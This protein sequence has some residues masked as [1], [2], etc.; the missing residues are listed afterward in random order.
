ML[1]QAKELIYEINYLEEEV[2]DLEK[3]VLSLY[4][5]FF[6][7]SSYL[8]PSTLVQEKA[9]KCGA[10]HEAQQ[11]HEIQQ[12]SRK[13]LLHSNLTKPTKL[14]QSQYAHSCCKM[15]KT[16]EMYTTQRAAFSTPPTPSHSSSMGLS[17]SRSI[18]DHFH[19]LD[20]GNPNRAR[21]KVGIYTYNN[22]T[23]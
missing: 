9:T 2:V 1:V 8:R 12:K 19:S 4:R 17:K 3:H 22:A 7:N 13:Q 21:T 18:K 15:S 10:N 11:D 6:R 20:S 5:H 16:N 23:E 14:K